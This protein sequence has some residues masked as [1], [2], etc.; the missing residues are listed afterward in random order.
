MNH[1]LGKKWVL[2]LFALSLLGVQVGDVAAQSWVDRVRD[3]GQS[4]GQSA[5]DTYERQR[6]AAREQRERAED[7]VREQSRQAAERAR[8]EQERLRRQAEDRARQEQERLARQRE[9]AARQLREQTQR[10]EAAAREQ[11]R[12]A[13]ERARVQSEQAARQLRDQGSR[14]GSAVREYGRETVD[15]S[16]QQLRQHGRDLQDRGSAFAG[17]QREHW[18]A[19]RSQGAGALQERLDTARQV[20]QGGGRDV[21]VRAANVL[22]DRRAGTLDA[23]RQ[24]QGRISDRGAF[25]RAQGLD[26]SQRGRTAVQ[27]FGGTGAA[28]VRA[29]YEQG[30]DEFL[31]NVA[32]VRN[33]QGEAALIE[34]ENAV[35]R[36]GTG[37]GQGV[38]RAM[39]WRDASAE[40][41][42]ELAAP[43]VSRLQVQVQDPA[44]RERAIE[45]AVL[46]AAVLHYGARHKQDLAYMATR[47]ALANTTVTVNGQTQAVDSLITGAVVEQLPVL[48]GTRLAED[49]AAVLVYG[50]VAVG[51]DD[52]MNHARFVPDG[53]GDARTINETLATRNM[54]AGDA[55][56][57][58]LMSASLEGAMLSAA[59]QGHL[60]RHG[61]AFV[62]T[63]KDLDRR[64]GR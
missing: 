32:R 49:P 15:R 28:R 36:Y 24:V 61:L 59:E 16:Q 54:G 50:V 34:I 10:A 40:D 51:K 12:Q 8:Q 43:T 2:A 37:A 48:E 9:Q 56:T 30:S 17:Q 58:L 7:A 45:A 31:L 29:A 64:L 5:R 26:V 22:A 18:D 20:V 21:S 39:A 60:G 4:A 13:A 33:R 6:D 14:A 63:Q 3:A 19:A 62:A 1:G 41:L 23:A 44:T 52:L 47:A 53:N 25:L 11:A 46:S 42:M 38:A 27:Q 35:A 55:A 57:T